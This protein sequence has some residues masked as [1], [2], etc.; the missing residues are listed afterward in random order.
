MSDGSE[1][2]EA[3]EEKKELPLEVNAPPL[4][5]EIA[6]SVENDDGKLMDLS[7]DCRKGIRIVAFWIEPHAPAPWPAV[8]M[9]HPAPGDRSYF[10]AEG[11]KLARAG[12]ASLLID[13]PWSDPAWGPSLNAPEDAIR[14]VT[15]SFRK[16][17]RGI[18]FLSSLDDVDHD[19]MG[20]MGISLGALIGGIVASIDHRLKAA[21]LMSGVGSFTDVASLN[22]PE[23]SGE[24]LDH[25]RSIMMAIDPQTY[26]GKAAPT[27]LLFQYGSQDVFPREKLAAYAE[28]GSEPKKITVYEADHYLNEQA[29]DDAVAW[30][31]EVL[32]R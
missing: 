5:I 17:Q 22:V 16:V 15:V 4:N 31:A 26:I 9:V 13:A 32:A 29:R 7:F 23:L 6:S 20:Y 25:Y 11:W 3:S 19:R 28:A 14:A 10:M 30:L 27:Q 21:V 24:A 8:L 1:D 2:Q 18:E 12:I